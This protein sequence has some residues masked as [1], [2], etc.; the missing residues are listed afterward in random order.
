MPS[1]RSQSRSRSR[2]HPKKSKHSK[3]SKD[4]K[5]SSKHRKR[6]RSD[7]RSRTQDSKKHGKRSR[8]RSREQS[9][10]RATRAKSPANNQGVNSRSSSRSRSRSHCTNEAAGRQSKEERKARQ[11]PDSRPES[12]SKPESKP[13]PS[14]L[15][16]SVAVQAESTGDQT[17]SGAKSDGQLV[18]QN[19]RGLAAARSDTDIDC[20]KKTGGQGDATLG[21]PEAHNKRHPRREK[22]HIKFAKNQ[23]DSSRWQRSWNEE[24]GHHFFTNDSSGKSVWTIPEGATYEDAHGQ[25]SSAAACGT[26]LDSDPKT[27]QGGPSAK[28]SVPDGRNCKKDATAP[29]M[30]TDDTLEVMLQPAAQ[31][32]SGVGDKITGAAGAAND[33]APA[34]VERSGGEHTDAGAHTERATVEEKSAICRLCQ[35]KFKSADQ[36][37][38]HCAMSDLHRQKVAEAKV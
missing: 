31:R 15:G 34:S 14:E 7:S 10:D 30:H 16:G 38:K 27:P 28:N 21:T 17:E 22:P 24:V 5:R 32:P 8:E 6:S 11:S 2:E 12:A 9:R 3:H 25:A 26:A 19:E 36:L 29:N 20:T 4:R 13:A 33:A 35:R 1:N 18:K 37:A 23:A